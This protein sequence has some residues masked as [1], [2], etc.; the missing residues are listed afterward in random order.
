MNIYMVMNGNE[1]VL[2]TTNYGYARNTCDEIDE[3]YGYGASSLWRM[4]TNKDK[5]SFTRLNHHVNSG[6]VNIHDNSTWR[7]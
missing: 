6:S 7:Y 2:E 1:K 4:N 3:K 5:P